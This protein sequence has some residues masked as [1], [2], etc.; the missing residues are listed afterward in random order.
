MAARRMVTRNERIIATNATEIA[1]TRMRRKAWRKRVS[2][3]RPCY[4]GSPMAAGIWSRGKVDRKDASTP[5]EIAR[6]DSAA[7]RL[8]APAAEGEAKAHPGPVAA[9]LLERAKQLLTPARETAAAVLDFDEHAL[10]ADPDTQRDGGT[11][12][13]E[14]Q[15]VLHQVPHHRRESRAVG[16]D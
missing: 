3:M 5:G 9:P 15:R 7:I 6:I 12:P 1:A 10:G 13:R 2:V 11:R 14:L 8:R 16:L 4:A